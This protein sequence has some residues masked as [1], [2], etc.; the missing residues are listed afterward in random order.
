MQQGKF[1]SFYEFLIKAFETRKLRQSPSYNLKAGGCITEEA[2]K[3][4]KA[5]FDFPG[6]GYAE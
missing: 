4:P 2:S 1:Y 6:K 3:A 5:A